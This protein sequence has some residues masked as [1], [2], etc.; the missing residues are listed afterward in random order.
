MIV[1]LLIKKC[2]ECFDKNNIFRDCF[3]ICKDEEKSNKQV[4]KHTGVECLAFLLSPPL[5]NAIFQLI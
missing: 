4:E 3:Q 2:Y 5:S 1:S